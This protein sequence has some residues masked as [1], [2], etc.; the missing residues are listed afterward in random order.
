MKSRPATKVQDAQTR[1]RT[2]ANWLHY[3]LLGLLL[4]VLLVLAPIARAQDGIEHMP[5]VDAG[6]GISYVT[7]GIGLD[8]QAEMKEVRGFCNLRLTFALKG[9]GK[10][11]ADIRLHVRAPDGKALLDVEAVGPLFHAHVPPGKYVIIAERR[12][13]TQTKSAVAATGGAADLYFYWDE[14]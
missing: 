11:L 2:H 13:G 14:E 6:N 10:Y 1:K 5:L 12:N 4:L 7:G 3:V 8:Q 9:S